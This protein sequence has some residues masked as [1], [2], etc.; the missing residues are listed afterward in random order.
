ML[1]LFSA[2]LALLCFPPFNLWWL[3]YCFAVPMMVYL[4]DLNS[5]KKGFIAGCVFGFL[6]MGAFHSWI[7]E[8][9]PWSGWIPAFVLWLLL[10]LYLSVFYGF[11]AWLALRLKDYIPIHFGLP[12]SLVIGEWLR[13]LGPF[14]N[15]AGVIGYSQTGSLWTIVPASLV[16]VF[17]LSLICLLVNAQLYRVLNTPFKK[18]ISAVLPLF[19]ILLLLLFYTMIWTSLSDP[20]TAQHPI[21]VIQANHPQHLKLSQ[22]AWPGIK[23]DYLTLTQNQN[24]KRMIF[25][26][27]TIIPT[28]IKKKDPFLT[29]LLDY[30][31]RHDTSIVFGTPI[32]EDGQYYNAL[33]MMTPKGLSPLIYQKELLMPFGEYLPFE[34]LLTRLL[35]IKRLT[36]FQSYASGTNT[37]LLT[38]AGLKMGAGICLES[39]YPSFYRNKTKEGADF[40]FVAVNNAWFSDSSAAAKHLQMS[41]LRA[42][43]NNRYMVQAANTGLSAIID[44]FG[45][46]PFQSDLNE[47]AILAGT[48]K[49]GFRHSP[50]TILGDFVVAFCFLILGGLWIV[51]TWK[52]YKRLAG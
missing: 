44:R 46:L 36:T 13:S 18:L 19:S 5:L 47:Q 27:E 2:L 42:V 39:I 49:T 40:L 9:H 32:Q 20:N 16:G 30:S 37:S 8:L 51:S 34:S 28:L 35:P 15:T 3:S 23:K 22:H 25:L 52:N 6:F 33:Q 4:N 12:L 10:S 11:S 43:E 17:G 7:F 24:N 1:I 50:Y 38:V 21:A 48:I 14:G 29:S 41:R 26:P 31:K 45:Q